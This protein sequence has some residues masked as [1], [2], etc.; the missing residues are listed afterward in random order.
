MTKPVTRI[1]VTLPSNGLSEAV[2]FAFPRVRAAS[3]QQFPFEA[4]VATGLASPNS[5]KDRIRNDAN[6]ITALNQNNAGSL[7]PLTFLG[8]REHPQCTPLE[9]RAGGVA[10]GLPTHRRP[11]KGREVFC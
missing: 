8:Q 6:P 11:E 1:G 7:L 4:P 10:R 2:R 5:A 3:N 9:L